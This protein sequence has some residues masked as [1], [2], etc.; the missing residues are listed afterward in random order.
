M[1]GSVDATSVLPA[2]KEDVSRFTS[3]HAIQTHVGHSGGPPEVEILRTGE[4]GIYSARGSVRVQMP[5]LEVFK[6]LTNPEENKRIFERS[7]ASVN[8]HKLIGEDKEAQTRLFEVSKTGRWRV[9]G[10][11]FHFESTV[12]ALEDWRALEISFGLKKPGAMQHLSGF[13]RTIPIGQHET[14]FLYYTEAVPSLPLPQIFRSV[15][16]RFVRTLCEALLED[17]RTYFEPERGLQAG[18]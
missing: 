3:E 13:W 15:A 1:P 11:P 6:R 5:A 4:D 12:F 7:C 2:F 18:L 14:L 9:L 17:V 16:G 10:I 8:Y